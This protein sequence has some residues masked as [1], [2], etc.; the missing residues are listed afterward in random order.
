MRQLPEKVS[1]TDLVNLIKSRGVECV[2]H[3]VTDEKIKKCG[4]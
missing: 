1:S 3:S 2:H 4:K